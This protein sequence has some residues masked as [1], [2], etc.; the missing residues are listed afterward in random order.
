MKIPRQGCEIPIM[1]FNSLGK[2]FHRLALLVNELF[3]SREDK[4]PPGFI[5]RQKHM[6]SLMSGHSFAR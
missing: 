5:F 4:K 1:T 6:L 3:S 2:Y